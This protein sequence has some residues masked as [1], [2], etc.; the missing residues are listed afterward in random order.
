MFCRKHFKPN[1]NHRFRS[2]E[3][4]RGTVSTGLPK[5]RREIESQKP[6]G[7]RPAFGLSSMP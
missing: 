1:P 6:I 3:S 5:L 2:L 4:I 7:H